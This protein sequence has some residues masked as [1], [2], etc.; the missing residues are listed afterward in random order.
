MSDASGFRSKTGAPL[1]SS[2]A[3]TPDLAGELP[4]TASACARR[5]G[6]GTAR[7]TGTTRSAR[8]TIRSARRMRAI[9]TALA[10]WAGS[11]E[12]G[13]DGVDRG[14]DPVLDLKLH[15]D[16]RDVV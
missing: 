9:V 15:Q 10:D 12:P 14:L 6:R 2:I 13:A 4:G 8:K 11:G 3:I 16:V 5:V 1:G 7:A